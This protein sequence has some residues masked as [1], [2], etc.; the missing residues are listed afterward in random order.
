MIDPV[1]IPTDTIS[2]V[3]GDSN[4][5]LP[6]FVGMVRL[7]SV[8]LAE[9]Y[10]CE[11]CPI[12]IVSESRLIVSGVE[13]VKT[14]EG[15]VIARKGS[16]E[17]FAGALI[18]GLF[19]L[20]GAWHHGTMCTDCFPSPTPVESKVFINFDEDILLRKHLELG[21]VNFPACRK[22]L[23][24]ETVG[25]DP[26]CE[27]CELSKSVRQTIPKIA[28][29]R[30]SK[31]IYRLFIDLSGRKRASLNNYRYYMLVIDDYSRK[32]W[33]KFLKKKSEA[34]GSLSEVVA[35]LQNEKSPLT[36][37]KIRTDGGGEFVNN[38]MSVFCTDLG[39]THEKSAPY[40]QFQNGVV[41][42]S[43]GTID[44]GSR[45]MLQHAN[46]PTYDWPYSVAHSVYL[47]NHVPS[48]GHGG[49]QES[50]PEELFTGVEGDFSCKGVF[51]CLGYAK[52]YVRGKQEPTARKVV[53][54]GRSIEYKADMV[55]DISTYSNSLREFYSRD[56]KYDTSIFPY[57]ATVV[58]RPVTPP[59]DA[60]DI[61]LQS[62]LDS[63]VSIDNSESVVHLC[64]PDTDSKVDN[65]DL[66]TETVDVD[67]DEK[68]VD[69]D[70]SSQH[71][72]FDLDVPDFPEHHKNRRNSSRLAA[73]QAS[74][75]ALEKIV[76]DNEGGTGGRFNTVQFKKKKNPLTSLAPYRVDPNTRKQA[77]DSL[78]KEE[79]L[80]A[81]RKELQSIYSHQV[82]DL[83]PRTPGMNVLGCRF[84]YKTKR[85]TDGSV[86]RFKV[87]LVA[88]GFKQRE[89]IDFEETYASTVRM[90]SV[91]LV[92]WLANF[93][94]MVLWK[95][96]IETFFLYGTM[97]ENVYMLQPPGYESGD[98]GTMVCKLNKS[99]YGTKQAMRYANEKLK[100]VL[101]SLGFSPL[102]SDGNV[103]TQTVGTDIILLCNFVD[104][105][106]CACT[107]NT[108]MLNVYK[109]IEN[110]FRCT[111][112]ADPSVYLSLQIERDVQA[113]RL[114][115]HQTGYTTLLLQDFGMLDC[116]PRKVP[117]TVI[118]LPPRRLVVLDT[119][120][121]YQHL[122]GRLIWLTR[123]R[124]DISFHV[125]VLCRYMSKYNQAVYDLALD[126]LKYLNGVKHFGIVYS[127]GTGDHPAFGKGVLMS[128]YSDA[129][130]A[131]RKEDSKSTTGWAIRFN[132]S[133]VFTGSSAQQRPATSTTVTEAELTGAEFVCHEV[134]W[135][136]G[137]LA[138]IG[139]EIPAPTTLYQDNVGGIRL[140]LDDVMQKRT[141]Y[142]RIA[143]AYIRWCYTNE[144]IF[145]EYL[146][147]H[148][149][150]C[151][152]LNKP[153]QYASFSR[154]I[155]GIMGEQ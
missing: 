118:D 16:V 1:V 51:G 14:V 21:H 28:H 135:Y 94:R 149:M 97:K 35:L 6:T 151:D 19:Q 10:F 102:K 23:D 123:T 59:L 73:K 29:T 148:E 146:S 155:T 107:S 81:E 138:E 12:K 127:E 78:Q 63:E 52:V 71:T 74:S 62:E 125:G 32:R 42:R 91:R 131:G 80:E 85:H 82:W 145:P 72:D 144:I 38:A 48:N 111:Y 43:M 153:L 103:F 9:V 69:P 61:K 76:T 142:F 83:V 60:E 122:L 101:L 33:V 93:Y 70:F 90:Q 113:R 31:P 58:P 39:I 46:S 141:K 139:V 120:L 114:K 8:E 92:L 77:L 140:T 150:F 2:F 75:K 17:L 154:H 68:H 112:E 56:V 96:D 67:E 128:A 45:A 41:E 37:A 121:N 133:P 86:Y 47:S 89:G 44:S 18:D 110:N 117:F 105:I 143:Q 115:I 55:R 24:M 7:G 147:S 152:I 104:D 36:V 20:V 27:S 65:A 137:F 108:L 26:I 116:K 57:R 87:R 25:P 13:V 5:M 11:S 84:V 4:K 134:E 15:T 54:L 66:S 88:Q 79:W 119:S 40:S 34:G 132:N 3:V 64:E 136:R 126:V 50:T 95:V 53:F 99:L 49:Q 30:S 106:L 22:V 129:D 100:A 124:P 109:G 98:V 130:W